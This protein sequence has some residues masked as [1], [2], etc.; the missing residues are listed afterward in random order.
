MKSVCQYQLS[1]DRESLHI[2]G[3][4]PRPEQRIKRIAA[5]EP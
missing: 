5:I 1:G 3:R 2:I 4:F